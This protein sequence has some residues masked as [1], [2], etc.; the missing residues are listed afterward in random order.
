MKYAIVESGGKQYKAV[1]GST[2]EVDRLNMEAGDKHDFDSVLLV[3]HD[4]SVVVGTPTIS[5]AKVAATVVKEFKG[6]KVI[7]YKYHSSKRYRLKKGHRQ[8]YT[9]LQIEAIEGVK[10][11]PKKKAEK[12]EEPKAEA[13]PKEKAAPKAEKPVE[14]KVEA[15]AESG[16]STRKKV[17]SLD[18]NKRSVDAMEAAD[19]NTVSQLLKLLAEGDKA[20]LDL[21]GIGPKG[22]GEIKTVLKDAGYDLP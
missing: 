20:V 16:P 8:W 19:V 9:R 1:E 22:L 5:G 13:K 7:I 2:I 6:P 18:L 21:E 11:T 15:P 12:A 14:E 4:G 3:S 10:T 17:S